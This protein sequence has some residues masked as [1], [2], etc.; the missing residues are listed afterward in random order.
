MKQRETGCKRV[1]GRTAQELRAVAAKMAAWS[2]ENYHEVFNWV[3]PAAALLK[4]GSFEAAA[5]YILDYSKSED[6]KYL[7]DDA[8]GLVNTGFKVC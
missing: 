6:L 5:H 7:V 3:V 4:S 8:K 2:G 1:T